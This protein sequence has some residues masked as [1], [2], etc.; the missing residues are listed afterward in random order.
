MSSLNTSW[1]VE[2]ENERIISFLAWVIVVIILFYMTVFLYKKTLKRD[3]PVNGTTIAAARHAPRGGGAGGST[4]DLAPRAREVRPPGRNVTSSFH[5]EGG[6]TTHPARKAAVAEAA[7]DTRASRTAASGPSHV[8]EASATR[9]RSQA[10]PVVKKPAPAARRSGK[11]AAVATKNSRKTWTKQSGARRAGLPSAE[12]ALQKK[13][14]AA[15]PGAGHRPA[16]RAT[17]QEKHGTGR[18][19]HAPFPAPAATYSVQVGTFPSER[20]AME[21]VGSITALRRYPA[22]TVKEEGKIYLRIGCFSSSQAAVNAMMEISDYF[23]LQ[24]EFFIKT[25]LP[26]AD[27]SSIA[28]AVQR[29]TEQARD[30]PP[31]RKAPRATKAEKPPRSTASHPAGR[32]GSTPRP[33]PGPVAEKKRPRKKTASSGLDEASLY[34]DPASLE[35]RNAGIDY[36]VPAVRDSSGDKGKKAAPVRPEGVGEEYTPLPPG[37]WVQVGSFSRRGNA[38]SLKKRLLAEGYEAKVRVKEVDGRPWY[39]VRV[40]PFRTRSEALE[41]KQR[42]AAAH[43]EL[44]LLLTRTLP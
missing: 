18:A 27:R 39:R 19:G 22:V 35:K 12:A 28:R 23:P 7:R 5:L 44:S 31:Q 25:N 29:S 8:A 2:Q 24:K 30:V 37:Y 41:T 14:P 16:A 1:G 34:V 26:P 11:T 36:G 13:I 40:G 21:K 38:F 42:L 32:I 10:A 15:V 33:A 43:P 9:M 17:G 4:A 20:D 6:P 3:E